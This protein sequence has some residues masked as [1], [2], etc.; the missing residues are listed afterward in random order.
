MD[1]LTLAYIMAFCVGLIAVLIFQLYPTAGRLLTLVNSIDQK[2]FDAKNERSV[3]ALLI[4]NSLSAINSNLE[5]IK[6]ILKQQSK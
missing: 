4:R 3:D 5:D 2:N 6:A 1:V